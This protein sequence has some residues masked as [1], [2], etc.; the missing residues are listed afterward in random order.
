MELKMAKRIN[1]RKKGSCY[2]RL[3]AKKL[4][5]WSNIKIRRSPQSGGWNQRGDLVPVDPK[6]MVEWPFNFELK[7]RENW[8]L[9]E[10]LTGKNINTGLFSFWDQCTRDAKI[11]NK[12]PVLVFSKNFDTDYICIEKEFAKSIKLKKHTSNYIIY[13]NLVFFLFE[14]FLKI[15]YKKI[16]CGIKKKIK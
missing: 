12:I 15:D 3:I 5:E 6:D 7:K 1:S 10:L 9:S 16:A 13:K 2:E 8:N 11:S 4:S 14:D